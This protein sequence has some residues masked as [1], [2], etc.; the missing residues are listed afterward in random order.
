L[1]LSDY[2]ANAPLSY[3]SARFHNSIVEMV[4]HVSMA[5][6][7]LSDLNIVAL[8]GGVWQN[9]FLLERTVQ[10]LRTENFVVLLHNQ[11]PPNDAGV[12][13]GQAIVAYHTIKN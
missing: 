2:L 4:K 3:I 5:I 13:L 7:N 9:I 10:A 6:R 1:V 11:L 8:S 12:A